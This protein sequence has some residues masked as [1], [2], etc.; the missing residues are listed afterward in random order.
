MSN[1]HK[2]YWV[3]CGDNRS[4]FGMHSYY[5]D[6]GSIQGAK[7]E[8]PFSSHYTD[9]LVWGHIYDTKLRKIVC[10]WSEA[11]GWLDANTQIGNIRRD[12]FE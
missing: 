7:N 1:Q 11:E 6:Y 10:Q 4:D 12:R 5:G 2:R 8:L 3:F 9:G